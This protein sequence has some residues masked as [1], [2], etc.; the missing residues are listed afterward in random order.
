[1]A[2]SMSDYDSLPPEIRKAVAYASGAIPVPLEIIKRRLKQGWSAASIARAI[3]TDGLA[4]KKE[5][6][7]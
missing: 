6:S 5:N 1:M 4:S 2:A 7:K 3:R